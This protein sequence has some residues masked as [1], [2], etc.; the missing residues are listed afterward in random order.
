MA[1]YAPTAPKA[2][3][4]TLADLELLV[5]SGKGGVGRTTVAALLGLELAARGRRTLV[6]TTGHDDRLAW[7]LGHEQLADTPQRVDGIGAASG[8]LWVQRLVPST[9]IREYGAIMLRSE[10]LSRMVFGNRVVERMLGA[11]P[12]L[13]DYAVLGKSWHEASRGDDFDCVVF[14]GAASGHLVLNLGVPRTIVETA[15]RGPLVDEAASIVETLRDP[16]RAAAVLVGLPEPWPLTELDELAGKLREDV[17][18]SLGAVVVNKTW[19][20]AEV[21][22]GDAE[23]ED[24]ADG[25]AWAGLQAAAARAAAQA[26][27]LEEWAAGHAQ[28]AL[29]WSGQRTLELPVVADGLDR[30]EAFAALRQS[31]A[32]SRQEGRS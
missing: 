6:A 8:G 21:E 23:F 18:L 26:D 4:D 31:L 17:G 15:P 7:M 19:P 3:F 1:G 12:G 9:C 11:V 32:A 24:D 20:R 29:A 5:V 10:R 22:L 28:Q 30:P 2:V 27:A 16:A 13:D 14:D 25:R